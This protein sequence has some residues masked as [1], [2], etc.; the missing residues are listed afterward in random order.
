MTIETR[1]P[2][3]ETRKPWLF[4]AWV[5]AV[6][7]VALALDVTAL[8]HW[9]VVAFVAIVPAIVVRSLWRVPDRTMSESIQDA[10]R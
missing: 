8:T 4:A 6:G 2:W 9:I 1:K 3:L 5:V 10:R 7:L